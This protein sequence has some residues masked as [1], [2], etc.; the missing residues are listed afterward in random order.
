ME[1]PLLSKLTTKFVTYK[2]E[3]FIAKRDDVF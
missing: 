3:P 1:V 2:Y